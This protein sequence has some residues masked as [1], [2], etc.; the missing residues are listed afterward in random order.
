MWVQ[1]AVGVELESLALSWDLVMAL[2]STGYES[3]CVLLDTNM[4]ALRQRPSG[5]SATIG[6]RVMAVYSGNYPMCLR[7]TDQ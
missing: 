2:G 5:S 1:C 3:C 6:C 4:V 7:S